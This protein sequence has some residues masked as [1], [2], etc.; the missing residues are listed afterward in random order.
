MTVSARPHGFKLACAN[1]N[2]TTFSEVKANGY[3]SNYFSTVTVVLQIIPAD[4]L[5]CSLI[6][7][8]TSIIHV[9]QKI[10]TD[11]KEKKQA[12]EQALTD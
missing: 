2:V 6:V 9:I 1:C 8:Q 12:L 5:Q 10:G 7:H 11:F 4:Y 3:D